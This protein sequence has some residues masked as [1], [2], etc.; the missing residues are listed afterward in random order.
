MTDPDGKLVPG[1][2]DRDIVTLGDLRI[3]LAGAAHDD[4]PRMSNPGDIEIS[5]NRR[6]HAAQCEALRRDGADLVV[7]VMHVGS[8]AGARSPG[9]TSP[10]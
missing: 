5:A 3:G 9:P 10:M 8:L 2:K 4:T 1:F 7:V 6:D